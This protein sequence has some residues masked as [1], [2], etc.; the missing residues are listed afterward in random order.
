LDPASQKLY[1]ARTTV[2]RTNSELKDGFL[3][4]ILTSAD[5]MHDGMRSGLPFFFT[6]IK[7]VRNVLILYEELKVQRVS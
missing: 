6:T 1:I 4:D 5:P 7:K 3:P 2:G